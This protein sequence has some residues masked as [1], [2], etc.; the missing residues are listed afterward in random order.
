MKITWKGTASIE[1]ESGDSKIIFDPF[2]PYPHSD[3]PVTIEDFD[4]YK[5]IFVTHG[6]FDHIEYIPEVCR[7]NPDAMVYCTKA[8]YNKLLSKGVPKESL[9]L[10]GNNEHCRVVGDEF[11]S[12]AGDDRT[13]GIEIRTYQGRHAI[14][15]ADVCR[16]FSDAF[17]FHCVSNF[18]RLLHGLLAY[19]EN[20]ETLFYEI[21]AEGKRI[22]LMGSLNLDADTEY[23]EVCDL[24]VLPYNGW[25]DNF[26]HAVEIADKL[27]P[28]KILADHY[29][30]TF[31]PGTT[32]LDLTPLKEHF[33]D[34]LILIEQK[35]SITL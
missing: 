7:R 35:S 29:D 25:D 28:A 21:L 32:D 13:D 33:G 3:V 1:I 17:R 31:R 6:H 10:I 30:T 23:P 18:P 14:L 34:R 19:P 5:H 4:G 12:E 27:K 26:P 22:F 24:M 8:P 2:V 16:V 20:K 11:I 15:K 9:T